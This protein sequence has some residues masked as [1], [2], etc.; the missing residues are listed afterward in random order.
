MNQKRTFSYLGAAGVGLMMAS[1]TISPAQGA[2]LEPCA[3]QE[4]TLDE[5]E[6]LNRQECNPFGVVIHLDD[7]QIAVA[8]EIDTAVD[9]TFTVA[10]GGDGLADY[11]V[12]VDQNG[13]IGVKF[14]DGSHTNSRGVESTTYGSANS[15]SR[16][17]Q[18][19]A[20]NSD[21]NRAANSCNSTSYALLGHTWKDVYR[22]EYGLAGDPWAPDATLLEYLPPLQDAMQWM[23][24]GKNICGWEKGYEVF[25]DFLGATER[26]P[27]IPA[28]I[29]GSVA[30]A[31]SD[32]HNVQ[33]FTFHLGGNTL[34]V[35]CTW[36]SIGTNLES[37]VGFDIARAWNTNPSSC[38]TSQYDYY[39]M[40]FVALH[41]NGH[42]FGLDHSVPGQIMQPTADY[43]EVQ[44]GFG[45]GDMI[46]LAIA[47][48]ESF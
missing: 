46:G 22:W 42:V 37:D 7:S 18:A 14:D 26:Q 31:G 19:P 30:C 9:A 45:S 13:D 47:N 44:Q 25:A 48:P 1:M 33:G 24:T 43:C 21:A 39:D 20:I 40:R 32:G 27:N 2:Q 28:Y 17:A 4:I 29:G 41:E 10:S 6:T 5:I 23:K 35:T 34:A 36:Y 16:H 12:A 8:P 11:T 15:I 3:A 38:S